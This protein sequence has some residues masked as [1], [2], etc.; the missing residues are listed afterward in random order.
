M[1]NLLMLQAMNKLKKKDRG[2]YNHSLRVAV[3]AEMMAS[4]LRLDEKQTYQLVNGCWLHDIGK[5]LIPI[6]FMKKTAS[7]SPIEWEMLKRYPTVGAEILRE[8]DK[9]DGHIIDIVELHHERWD[10]EGFPYGL[11]GQ[12]IPVFARICAIVDSFDNMVTG[13]PFHK[14]ISSRDAK[15][16]LLLHAGTQFDPY[17]VHI[18]ISIFDLIDQQL[19]NQLHPNIC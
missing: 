14:K 13:R 15:E 12:A 18:Y 19:N 6:Q 7:F 3:I 5:L 17:Y 10:G 1:T 2:I 4:H 8:L 11:G 9:I 16:Q